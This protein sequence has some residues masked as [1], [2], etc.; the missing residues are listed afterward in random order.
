MLLPRLPPKVLSIDLTGEE[1]EE[2]LLLLLLNVLLSRRLS[3]LPA[4]ADAVVG[5]LSF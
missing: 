5:I 2:T 1:E 4:D 3:L